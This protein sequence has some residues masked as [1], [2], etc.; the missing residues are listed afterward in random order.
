MANLRKELD[1]LDKR[2]MEKAAR[3]L[4]D[5]FL[6]I[7]RKIKE[8]QELLKAAQDDVEKKD[9]WLKESLMDDLLAQAKA[10]LNYNAAVKVAERAELAIQTMTDTLGRKR[11]SP[12]IE[13][14]ALTLQKEA[15]AYR[16]K[17]IDLI[18]VPL[19]EL[20]QAREEFLNKLAEF[21]ELIREVRYVDDLLG[22]V[23]LPF[24]PESE[25]KYTPALELP[26]VA[27]ISEEEVMGVIDPVRRIRA[28]GTID[29]S[30]LTPRPS[31]ELALEVLNFLY[32]D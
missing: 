2:P 26:Q 14:L 12:I 28:P 7:R 17:L 9:V 24:V 5:K 6:T 27:F 22:K 8:Q 1:G 10:E 29:P 30:V 25:K 4:G 15:L 19:K 16:L 13:S 20:T 18:P 3:N 11:Q 23:A 32:E 31:V 21:G